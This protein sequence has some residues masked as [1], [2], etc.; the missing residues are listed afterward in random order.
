MGCKCVKF[1]IIA[2]LG[3]HSLILFIQALILGLF[4]PTSSNATLSSTFTVEASHFIL[5][6]T[7]STIPDTSSRFMINSGGI[8]AAILQHAMPYFYYYDIAADVWYTKTTDSNVNTLRHSTI[9]SFF[10]T[11]SAIISIRNRFSNKCYF[12]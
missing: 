9:F 12:S 8:W 5:N 6:T 1:C 10:Y 4:C 7:W 11:Y 3:L 2:A